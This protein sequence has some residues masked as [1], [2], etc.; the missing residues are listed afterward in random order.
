MHKRH[1]VDRTLTRPFMGPVRQPQN[2]AAHGNVCYVDICTCGATR[3]RNVNNW[4]TEQGPWVLSDEEQDK[5][6]RLNA[7]KDEMARL[8]TMPK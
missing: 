2:R 3:R 4:A 1:R 5:R 8:S 7:Y 6:D